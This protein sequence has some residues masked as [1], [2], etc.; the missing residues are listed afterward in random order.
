MCTIRSD[1]HVGQLRA[2]DAAAQVELGNISHRECCI[3]A[4]A[5]VL[6]GLKAGMPALG[7]A[8]GCHV[9][10][11]SWTHSQGSS[12]SCALPLRSVPVMWTDRGLTTWR[13]KGF[14]SMP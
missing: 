3:V 10:C 12:T 5:H 13:F 9:R 1:R 14:P 7:Y 2:R 8:R 4:T 11:A 6:A